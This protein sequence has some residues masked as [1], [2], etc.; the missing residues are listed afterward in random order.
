[1]MGLKGLMDS[2]LILKKVWNVSYSI[3]QEERL[4]N[5]YCNKISAVY[6]FIC[7]KQQIL[8]FSYYTLQLVLV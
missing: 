3:T 4:R 1:M 2:T 6:S 8:L 7:Q 5:F